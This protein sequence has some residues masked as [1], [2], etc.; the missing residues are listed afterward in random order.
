MPRLQGQRCFRRRQVTVTGT[1]IKG[2]AVVGSNVVQLGQKEITEVGVSNV[3]QA[4]V[5]VPAIENLGSAGRGN[6]NSTNGQ[7]GVAIY[8]HDVGAMGSGSTL[9]LIDGH[10]A[11]ESGQTNYFVNPNVLPSN[12]LQRVDVLSDGSSAVYG[13]DAIAGVVNFITRKQFEGI[14]F[15]AQQTFMDGSGGTKA[16]LL[17]GHGWDSGNFVF[18]V[19]FA[20]DACAAG[21]RAPLDQS[22]GSAC[23]PAAAA[24][25]SGPNGSNFGSFNCSP[26]ALSNVAGFT[27]LIFLSPTATTTVTNSTANAP[28]NTAWQVGALL[29]SENLRKRDAQAFAGNP[30]PP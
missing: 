28:C 16:N 6:T 2:V 30:P 19:E 12:M 11:V 10:R 25:V 1:S 5:D 4:L 9:V 27:G 17:V 24:G 21:Y 14:Q 29:P 20:H 23:T 7:P 13:S 15:G 26:A 3:T 18:G 22:A 8:I